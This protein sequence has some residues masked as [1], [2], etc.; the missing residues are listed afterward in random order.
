MPTCNRSNLDV[1]DTIP[2]SA[3]TGL[4]ARPGRPRYQQS[5]RSNQTLDTPLRLPH[6]GGEE[7]PLAPVGAVGAINRPKS[8]SRSSPEP[9]PAFHRPVVAG[10]RSNLPGNGAGRDPPRAPAAGRRRAIYHEL[11]GT[12]SLLTLTLAIEG[13][14][15]RWPTASERVGIEM[16]CPRSP[17][18]P[19]S[20]RSPTAPSTVRFALDGGATV[21]DRVSRSAV[22]RRR[23]I[24]DVGYI[25]PEFDAAARP[26]AEAAPR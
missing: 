7:G 17:P 15:T 20:L 6:F 19:V 23:R 16:R 13:W 24:N 5:R 3:L 21:D 8:A 2:P 18:S 26:A 25:N 22:H 11:A 1:L 14:W 10:L 9:T 4:P 12:R